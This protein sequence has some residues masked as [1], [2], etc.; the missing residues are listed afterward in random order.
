MIRV[1]LVD[2]QTLVRQGIQM[3]LEIE[4]DIQV[5]G[6]AANGREALQLVEALRPDV[7]L[8]DVRM[9]EMDGVAATQAI[10][11][12]FPDTG[13]IILTT[14][15]DDE[16]VFGGL[17]AGARGYLLK[18]IS[19]EEMAQAI[20]KVAAGEAL[21]QPSITRKVLEE[22][23]RLATATEKSAN[24]PL[25]PALVE[26]LTERE[27]EVLSALAKGLSNREIARQLVITEGTVKNHVSSLI[28]K[29]EVRDR[30]Q[31]V[32]K[33]QELGLI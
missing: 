3:L 1:L 26:S 9:P 32:L 11:P 33:A 28:A 27:Q 18:D 25:Q 8:M 13:V 16:F 23:S 29:L 14:F 7:V 17:E 20:R 2:D 6:Q 21:I 4:T 24:K 12:R 15:E 22:F 30:T 31:A 5:V 10:S 19:S